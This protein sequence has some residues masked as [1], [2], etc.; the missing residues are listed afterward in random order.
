MKAIVYRVSILVATKS[1]SSALRR[2]N[3]RPLFSKKYAARA[4]AVPVLC[5]YTCCA[6]A[7]SISRPGKLGKYLPFRFPWLHASQITVDCKLALSNNYRVSVSG[8]PMCRSL[9]APQ[10]INEPRVRWRRRTE[11]RCFGHNQQAY[12]LNTSSSSSSS[13]R[14]VFKVTAPPVDRINKEKDFYTIPGPPLVYTVAIGLYKCLHTTRFLL[15]VY[16]P[17][18]QRPLAALW[19][20]GKAPGIKCPYSARLLYSISPNDLRTWYSF[21]W[22]ASVLVVPVR[23]QMSITLSSNKTKTV[24]G[25]RV[26]ANKYAKV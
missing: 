8:T 15:S 19:E 6:P 18:F 16:Q 17:R 5:A 2:L 12:T 1:L 4:R 7:H 11:T 22:A 20:E 10:I 9:Q 14:I 25:E 13:S 26:A 23:Y 3:K 21:D 24:S